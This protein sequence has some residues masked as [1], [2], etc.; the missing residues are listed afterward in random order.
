ML[1]ADVEGM[2][3]DVMRGAA[4]TLSRFRP[5]LYLENDRREKSPAL[6]EHLLGLGYRLYWHLPPMYNPR[7]YYG[8]AN[9]VFPHIVSVNLLGVHSSIK[10]NISGL[11]EVTSPQDFWRHD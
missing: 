7:N 9:N 2:E 8:N 3:L 5:L 1:K 10:S 4:Q 6:L 11:T